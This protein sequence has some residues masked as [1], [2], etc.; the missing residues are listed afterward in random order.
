M[1]GIAC[2]QLSPTVGVHL[3]NR[4]TAAH[5]LSVAALP[6]G[7]HAFPS[8]AELADVDPVELKSLGFSLAKARTIVTSARDPRW[9][10]RP[11]G[12]S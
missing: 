5:G 9:R 11:R 2:Q 1:N 6:E 12:P 7:L 8:P 4:L 10:T 3:L